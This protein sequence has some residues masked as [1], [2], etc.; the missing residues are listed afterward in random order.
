VS[1]SEPGDV[2]G[3]PLVVWLVGV[4]AIAV[5]F[6]ALVGTGLRGVLVVVLVTSAGLVIRA[7]YYRRSKRLSRPLWVVAA[8]LLL[9]AILTIAMSGSGGIGESGAPPADPTR[10]PDVSESSPSS[11]SEQTP[12]P[13]DS[14]PRAGTTKPSTGSRTTT[15]TPVV[16][17][18][19]PTRK[20]SEGSTS[21]FF[22]GVV[23]VG[24][25]DVYSDFVSVIF[26]TDTSS[27]SFTVLHVGERV[28]ISDPRAQPRGPT[29]TYRVTLLSINIAAA[30]FR[31]ERLVT[32][33]ILS[34]HFC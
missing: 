18:K 30:T 25:Q 1:A 2:S 31:V 13:A 14:S 4:V 23:V 29:V 24:L 34:G 16:G 20:V 32:D 10:S 21:E 12:T 22:D 19:A 8:V 5:G 17:A 11:P 7:A 3:H 9:A 26:N 27:C 6:G 28:V 15:P 33:A